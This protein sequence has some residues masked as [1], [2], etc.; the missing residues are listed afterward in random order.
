MDK[1][2]GY[3]A[4]GYKGYMDKEY[5]WG[6]LDELAQDHHKISGGVE[7]FAKLKRHVKSW[8][9]GKYKAE[10]RIKS[11]HEPY[12]EYVLGVYRITVDEFLSLDP[13]KIR[14]CGFGTFYEHC[15]YGE[16]VGFIL[17][18]PEQVLQTER[19]DCYDL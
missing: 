1:N 4:F 12:E 9:D 15:E 7:N 10:D 3:S 18:T 6:N 2:V 8:G 11:P 19:R 14:T 5:T 16:E 13:Y 17:V